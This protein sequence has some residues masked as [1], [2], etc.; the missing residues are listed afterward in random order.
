M[1]LHVE[2]RGSGAD[3]VLLHGWGMHGGVWADVAARLA[4]TCRVHSVDLP[5]HGYSPALAQ[6]NL[7]TLTQAV[8]SRVPEGAT[9]LGWSLGALVALNLAAQAPCRVRRLVLVS[10][11]PCF[12]GR[13]DWPHGMPA[14]QFTDFAARLVRD[15]AAAVQRFVA[16][17]VLGSGEPRREA[18]ALSHS[19]RA[20]PAASLG[21]LQQGLEI[22]R[23][24]DLRSQIGAVHVPA[25]VIHGSDDAIIPPAAGK[26]LA[27]A[28]PHAQWEVFERAGHAPF[29][30][31][32]ERFARIVEDSLH[33][34]AVRA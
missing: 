9:L 27:R 13:A 17:Q 20:R 3:L 6:T 5:G 31:Q 10:A 24:V 1:S 16:L 29:L 26:W 14:E 21:A 28:L 33:A 8:A 15:P 23:D 22:L 18:Q 12:V 7:G 30:S 32:A 2:S 34:A 25:C 11:T 19:L 4:R